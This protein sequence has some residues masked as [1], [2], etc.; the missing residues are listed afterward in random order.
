MSEPV[1]S[2]ILLVEDTT[3]LAI[4]YSEQLR[5]DGI[6]VDTVTCGEEALERLEQQSYPLVLLDLQLPDI[7]GFD[8]L[9]AI[10]NRGEA[11]RVIVVTADASIDRAVKA[12]RMGAN[13]YLVKPIRPAR[14][15]VTVRNALELFN[16]QQQLASIQSQSTRH[17]FQGFVGASKP[18]QVIYQAIE[19]VADSKATIFITGE[20]GTG[21]EVCAEAIH[22][23]GS[24]HDKPF[25]AINC[26]A[27]PGE[28]MESEIFGHLKG[29]FTGAASNRD[30]AATLASGGTLFLDEICEMD[31]PLQTKLLRFL[32]TGAIQRVGSNKVEKVD[33]RVVCATNRDPEK[34]VAEGRFREDLYYRL[35]VIPI[36]I[37]A[38]RER[39]EDVLLVAQSLLERFS[40]EEGKSFKGFSPDAAEA[41]VSYNWP[42]NVRELQ[43][44]IRRALVMHDAEQVEIDML[45]PGLRDE[46]PTVVEP[47]KNT[48]ESETEVDNNLGQHSEEDSQSGDSWVPLNLSLAEIE[49]TIIE[50]TI[51]RCDGSIPT[52]ARALGVSPSTLYRKR[53]SW[54]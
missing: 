54:K 22:R 1:T 10:R 40:D 9:R 35:N 4:L 25:V 13:D 49:R 44:V 28:L 42:G 18:M 6:P 19:N 47:I 7:D 38:L 17:Q 14:L 41:L 48:G 24:R 32:Q 2:P 45:P 39:G 12:M 21:K 46:K 23:C 37:P 26:G 5:A 15:L 50:K 3:S 31:A 51:S 8:V 53:S 43:N 16:L 20:S 34:E 52:A 11:T 30:G 33:V 36:H 27:I 29:A